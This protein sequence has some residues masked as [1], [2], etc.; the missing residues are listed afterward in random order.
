MATVLVIDDEAP[1]A[2][3]IQRILRN[4]EVTCVAVG[5]DALERIESGERYDVIFCDVHLPHM[6][7]PEFRDTVFR[8]DREQARRIVFLSGAPFDAGPNRCITKPFTADDLQATV[9]DS[10]PFIKTADGSPHC[11]RLVG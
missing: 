2:R 10:S 9:S 3:V 1:V 8:I 11:G 4:H 7:G 5:S 6:S